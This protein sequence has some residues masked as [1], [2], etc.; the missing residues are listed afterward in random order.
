MLSTDMESFL[1]SELKESVQSK[2][3]WRIIGNQTVLAR[4][5]SPKLEDSAFD[6]LADTLNPKAK[7]MLEELVHLGELNLP[8]DL[9]TW[10]GYPAARERF[11][12]LAKDQEAKDL[13]VL[14]GD[15][16][17]YW[18]NALYDT[19]N[20]NMGVELGATGIS[21]PRSLRSLGEQL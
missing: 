13:L 3:R 17:S 18:A 6:G 12:Q 1:R 15:S 20:K 4:S 16:H 11:Y 7:K 2:R 14:S 21:S 19:N 5:L 8:A 10:D 9:D